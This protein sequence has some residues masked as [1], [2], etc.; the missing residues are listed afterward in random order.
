MDS[1]HESRRT[2]T[3]V[4]TDV[5]GSTA[6]GET[7]DPEA[8]RRVM[9]RYFET[10]SGALTR[11]GGTVEKFIGDAVMAVFGVPRL[12][13]D[14]ALRAVR[15]AADMRD[16]LA[17]LNEE[18]D[19]DW[20]VRL[21]T[22]TGVNTGEVV[23]GDPR[24]GHALV[25]GDA[26]NVAARLEQLAGPGEILIGDTTRALTENAVRVESV[27][28]LEA[29]G[30]S[31][32]VP[33]W[34]LI[35]VVDESPYRRRMDTALVGRGD[36]LRQLWDAYTRIVRRQSCGLFTVV[37]PG[38]IGKSRLIRE[39]LG[40]L[41]GEAQVLIG[42]CLPY[43]EG[44][45]Y[46]PLVEIIRAVAGDQ[47]EPGLQRAMG[48]DP[49]GPR[50]ARLLAAAAGAVIQPADTE[51]VTWAAR[52]LFESLSREQPLVIGFE[53]INFAEPTLLDLITE[54]ARW[55]R[56]SP[57]LVLCSARDE[58]LEERPTWAGGLRNATTVLLEP[59]SDDDAFAL[60]ERLLDTPLPED[61]RDRVIAL[62]GGNPLFVEQLLAT[63]STG[64]PA[65]V[66]ALSTIH[67]VISA[68]LDALPDEERSVL[69]CAS[70]IGKEFGAEPLA[71]LLGADPG[72]A[73]G[74]LLQRDLVRPSRSA[75]HEGRAYRFGHLLIRDSAY[76][77]I[78]KRRRTELHERLALWIRTSGVAAEV[79]PAE[80][81]G[82]HLEQA[83]LQ[84][85]ALG[86]ADGHTQELARDAARELAAAGMRAQR[87]MDAPATANLLGRAADLLEGLPED[88]LEILPEIALALIWMGRHE[89]AR[90][91]LDEALRLSVELG[92]QR[93]EQRAMLGHA[94]LLWSRT[95]DG[96]ELERAADRAVPILEQVGDAQ[97]L[98][99]VWLWRSFARQG[100]SRYGDALQALEQARLHLA[101]AGPMA[102]ERTVFGNLS[103]CL[104]VSDAP[105]DQAVARC[106]ELMEQERERHATAE[107]H[108]AIPLA[109]LLAG[110][111][112]ADEAVTLLASTTEFF[113]RSP[114][115]SRA[116]IAHYTGLAHQSAGNLPA[117]E[118]SLRTALALAEEHQH[119]PILCE[120]QASLATV[121]CEQGRA[122]EA[123]THAEASRRNAAP[124]DVSSQI[125]WR[126]ALARAKAETGGASEAVELASQAVEIAEG[127]DSPVIQGDALLADAHV[128][129]A[130]GLGDEAR[131]AASRAQRRY[132]DKGLT[133]CAERAQAFA[134][135]G[136]ATAPRV[137]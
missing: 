128:L 119:R 116:E 25:T 16:D 89:D 32:P 108:I 133:T 62:S 26:V 123:L 113:S 78:P 93:N 45:T 51:D 70:V 17:Q 129:A 37:G 110:S 83:Y 63:L 67:A 36:E 11:H 6:L 2:V 126:S 34:R 103:L 55:S 124:G 109:M 71:A 79:D 53:D 118:S 33:A 29:R 44:I 13:E 80:M 121:L 46:W 1:G 48:D 9:E 31:E 117:A 41:E 69:E 54:V 105:C 73:L 22:R 88:R 99:R 68:R 52:R 30:K 49:D 60:V 91:A 100:R 3:V 98:V 81:I 27:P 14:D 18:L 82:Y 39:F 104:W 90:A 92:D 77:R 21:Q 24:A 85:A 134:A 95:G 102:E 64:H 101:G 56:D 86:P 40:S 136:R 28:P 96:A 135:G 65:D 59:L 5:T 10:A 84:R 47:I 8:V 122:A 94:F 131:E 106:R 114:A 15:A 112:Q 43:G 61:V 57:L 58:L 127:T 107:A 125:A 137:Q 74:S 132:A 23:A 111:G 42:R 75:F 72:P 120:V 115:T 38:G 4:F 130:A 7:L 19:R 66:G 35:E 97:G 20:G 12:H 50:V 76:A 87:R